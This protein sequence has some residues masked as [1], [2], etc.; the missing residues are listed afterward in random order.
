MNLKTQLPGELRLFRASLLA[1]FIDNLGLAVVY[2]IFTSLIL[3]PYTGFLPFELLLATRILYLT[4]L[5]ASFPLMQFIGGPLFRYLFNHKKR[6]LS[7]LVASIG[8]SAG[9]CLTAISLIDK[10]FTLLVLSRLISGFF[11]GHFSV[12]LASINALY[13][14]QKTKIKSLSAVSKVTGLS[15]AFALVIGSVFSDHSLTSYFTPDLPFW[16]LTGLA[17]AHFIFILCQIQNLKSPKTTPNPFIW[18]NFFRFPV[19]TFYLSFFLFMMGWMVSLQFLSTFVF[20]HFRGALKHLSTL[21]TSVAL[22]WA[23]AQL[24]LKRLCSYFSCLLASLG[25][26]ALAL[27]IFSLTTSFTL[28]FPLILFITLFAALAW[29]SSL[30]SISTLLKGKALEINQ[31]VSTGAIMLAPFIGGLIG[32]Y[33]VRVIFLFAGGLLFLSFLTLSCCAHKLNKKSASNH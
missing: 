28:F 9:F 25:L 10:N 12:S 7:F 18:K 32:K 14:C 19:G 24:L 17:L 23:L 22:T 1:L 30:H 21:F 31:F 15:F 6:K 11:A 29:T 3:R 5:I 13:V 20:E 27:F 8:Q 33:D 2:P 16:I 26:G 4:L